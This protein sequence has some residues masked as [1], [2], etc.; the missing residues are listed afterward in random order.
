MRKR[1]FHI[2]LA[3]IVP[4]LIALISLLSLLGTYEIMKYSRREDA[5]PE[6]ILLAFAGV[7]AL[8]SIAT[9]VFLS[10]KVLRPM[11][12]FIEKASALPVVRQR[13]EA[14]L[15]PRRDETERLS[16]IFRHVADL[17]GEVEA[18]ELF[19][20]IVGKSE[21][22]RAVMTQVR[23]VARTDSTVL[24]LGESGTGKELVAHS[25]YEH[26]GRHDKPFIRLNCAAI[27]EGLLESELFGHEKG[28]FT[29]AHARKPG[30]FELAHGGT[31]FLDEVGDLP[32]GTQA[33]L[34]R[35]L[36]E[37]E[38][39]RVGGTAVLKADVRVVAAT[40]KD[41]AAMVESGEFRE[42]LFYRLN[43]FPILIPPL[44]MRRED[45]PLLVEHFL[46]L[47]DHDVRIEP[48]AMESLLHHS[49]PGNVREL[50]NVVERAAIIADEVIRSEHLPPDLSDGVPE[51]TSGRSVALP[52]E[53]GIDV[54]LAEAEKRLIL[55]ALRETGGVQ[56]QA[57]KLLGIKDRS[58][59]HRIKKYNIDVSEMRGSYKQ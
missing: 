33:K 45:V 48:E 43:V 39:E 35:V 42:D 59:W 58:L 32:A 7:V 16:A 51:G 12:L 46:S 22:M 20:S 27:P 25:V 5:D 19:P 34:L 17:L 57:A 10:R 2:R 21:A 56:V 31:I 54:Y 30:K 52:L 29:G 53:D 40:N 26:S 41:L 14:E 47:G 24:L 36:Q 15:E 11:E 50:A 13:A 1:F 23:K 18:R 55:R 44:R 8:A 49:W 38:Y 3:W 6:M 37:G 4:L 28:A 9:G